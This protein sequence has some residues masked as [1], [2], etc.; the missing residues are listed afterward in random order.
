[1]N[2]FAAAHVRISGYHAMFIVS[3][4]HVAVHLHHP[5]M[6]QCIR[7]WCCCCTLTSSIHVSVHSFLMLLLQLCG[8]HW[9]IHTKL[10]LIVQ[11][12]ARVNWLHF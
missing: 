9:R 8:T 3:T 7:S 5:F 4:T 2:Y 6:S 11:L 1:V 10:L 12:W